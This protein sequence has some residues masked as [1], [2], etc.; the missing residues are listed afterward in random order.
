MK[1][2]CH[3]TNIVNIRFTWKNSHAYVALLRYKTFAFNL[4]ETVYRCKAFSLL[5][6]EK[7]N[8][9][10][11][12]ARIV[13]VS[14]ETAA[15]A[16]IIAAQRTR[17]LTLWACPSKIQSDRKSQMQHV[18]WKWCIE[19]SC[20]FETIN[21]YFYSTL[22]NLFLHVVQK[23]MKVAPKSGNTFVY[24]FWIFLLQNTY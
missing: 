12:L 20:V 17:Q 1:H 10:L 21:L 8:D 16:S 7:H 4:S 14:V 6:N 15:I 9:L 18:I 5:L 24:G 3:L 2:I 19:R 22:E 11:Q 23:L 13:Q